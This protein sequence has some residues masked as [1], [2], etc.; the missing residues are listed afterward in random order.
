M[1]RSLGSKLFHISDVYC[2]A[3]RS[4]NLAI[5][6]QSGSLNQA[7]FDRHQHTTQ[8]R[9]WHTN[10][11]SNSTLSDRPLK[12]RLYYE[13]FVQIKQQTICLVF[14]TNENRIIKNENLNRYSWTSPGMSTKLWFCSHFLYYLCWI[15]F[16]TLNGSNQS[17]AA[18]RRVTSTSSHIVGEA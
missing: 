15:C 14:F 6:G 4:L 5:F 16:W 18:W 17:E 3:L 13:T 7:I 12:V 10:T 8:Q 11:V 1:R 2:N 9:F